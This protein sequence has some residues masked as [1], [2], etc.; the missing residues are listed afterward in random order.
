MRDATT[1]ARNKDWRWRCRDCKRMYTVRTGTVFEE[2]RLPLRHWCFAL[3]SAASN[4]K[5]VAALQISRECEISYKSAL[6]LMHRIR[7]GMSEIDGS[8]PKLSG[9]VEAD[10]TYVGGKPRYKG[11]HNKRGL[12]TAKI[13]IIA[14]VQRGGDVRARVLD[15]RVNSA[16]IKAALAENV[17]LS[18]RLIT[19]ESVAYETVGKMFA[20]GHET[21]KHTA[22]E[23][24]RG[25]V[26]SNTIEG[27]FATM[28]RGLIGV[29]HSASKKHLHRYVAQYVFLYNN[30]KCNDGERVIRLVKATDGKRLT[31]AQQVAG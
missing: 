8:Q 22:R 16:D 15:R 6:Y 26:H 14:V 17:D 29:H 21:V 30:R 20:G 25:D 2:T 10:E 24:V 19:D 7:R 5:G 9:T 18:S 28:K 12:G 11:P 31:Y 3:W 13:P 27:V 1:G 4:K 23:Y